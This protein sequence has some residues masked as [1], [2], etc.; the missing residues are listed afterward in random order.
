ML[1]DQN[2]DELVKL[3]TIFT[4]DR[5]R[6]LERHARTLVIRTS[7][8]VKVVEW[9]HLGFLRFGHGVH[10]TDRTP[11]HLVPSNRDL[12]A[13]AASQPGMAFSPPAR[14]AVRKLGQLV[15][16]SQWAAGHMF[17]TP[18]LQN[19]HFFVFGK[20]DEARHKNHWRGGPHVHLVNWLWPR[21]DPQVVW[22]SFV[23]KGTKPQSSLHI[24]VDAA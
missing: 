4:F 18:D 17:C 24:P 8:F 23:E 2:R 21:L 15:R 19:W 6:D 11:T 1:D 5:K 22:H 7:H 10:Y 16:E 20:E 3:L 14:K 9:C 13:I 12:A